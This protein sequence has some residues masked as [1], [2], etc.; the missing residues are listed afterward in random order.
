MNLL[1]H[2]CETNSNI[3]VFIYVNYEQRIFLKSVKIF[4]NY[5]IFLKNLKKMY[6]SSF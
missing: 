5:L 4:L 1:V 3:H 2:W 6:D